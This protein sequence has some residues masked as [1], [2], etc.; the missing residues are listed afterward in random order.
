M[1]DQDETQIK[2]VQ[3]YAIVAA[4]GNIKTRAGSNRGRVGTLYMSLASAKAAARA[5]GDSVVALVVP[6]VRPLFIRGSKA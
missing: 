3:A 2:G 4:D 1:D 6:K 5:P